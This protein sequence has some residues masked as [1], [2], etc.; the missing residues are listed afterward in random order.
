[1]TSRRHRTGFTLV[2]LLVV[3]AIIG[4]LIGMLLPAVQMVREAARRTT[5][6]SRMEQFGLAVQNY[7]SAHL[8]MPPAAN[9]VDY[10]AAATPQYVSYGT[11]VYLLPHL[12]QQALYDVFFNFTG[13]GRGVLSENKVPI[14]LCPSATQVD[15]RG[16]TTSNDHW[17]CHYL[18]VAGP[19]DG[20]NYAVVPTTSDGTVGQEGCFGAAAFTAPPAQF[21]DYFTTGTARSFTDILDGNS[22]TLLFAENSRSANVAQGFSPRRSGWAYGADLPAEGERVHSV[23]TV[24]GLLNVNDPEGEFNEEPFGSNH[25]GGLNVVMADGSTRFVAETVDPVIL[26]NVA[27]I[28]SSEAN[29]SLE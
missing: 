19:V 4:I 15:E 2:E 18:G 14:F 23:R 17:A 7:H 9:V 26:R 29:T 13:E 1:M 6:L 5:C 28:A 8:K 16:G 27:S 12:E 11:A 25:P 24:T 21:M 10:G 20:V 22:N 3:I